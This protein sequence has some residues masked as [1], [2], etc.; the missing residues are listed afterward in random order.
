M[1][2]VFNAILNFYFMN[3]YDINVFIS[4][5]IALN[6]NLGNILKTFEKLDNF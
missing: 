1:F 2:H 3:F 5:V 6:I 4:K